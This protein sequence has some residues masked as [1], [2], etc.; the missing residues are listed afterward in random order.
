LKPLLA[1]TQTRIGSITVCGYS[2]GGQAAFR[3]YGHATKAV[4][5]IDPT[6]SQKDLS[7]LDAKAIF[8]CDRDNWSEPKYARI[9]AAQLEA[10]QRINGG[11]Y[12]KD[13][14][15]KHG[16]YPKYFLTKFESKLI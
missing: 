10:E 6:T 16:A 12:E 4:G 7:K 5:L 14:N 3:D 8:S 9:V 15:V 11:V 13:T 2:L 1:Q